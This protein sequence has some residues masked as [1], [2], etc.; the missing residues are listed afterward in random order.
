MDSLLP[1]AYLL[2]LIAL[3]A[4]A[5]WAVTRQ[6]L[7]VRSD[8]LELIRL[9]REVSNDSRDAQALYALA[10]VQLR[11]RLYA[12]ATATL[13][14]ATKVMAS[15]PNEAK[16]VIQNALGF[17]LAAQKQHEAASRCYQLALRHKSDYPVAL[18]NLG[19][20]LEKLARESE[21]ASSY[22]KTL[23]LEPSNAT[24]QRRLRRLDR[25]GIAPD[26]SPETADRGGSRHTGSSG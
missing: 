14:K 4:G 17:S 24:A 2:A 12:Q 20:S 11:K 10:A 21:A 26:A 7:R 18:N 1:Q 16:A 15:Q 19:F 5:A 23:A 6:I 22:R 13:R 25:C 8:E 3:L 9:E